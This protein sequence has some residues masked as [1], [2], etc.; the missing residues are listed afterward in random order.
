MTGTCLYSWSVTEM[1]KRWFTNTCNMYVEIK[2]I[3]KND[4]N[5]CSILGRADGPIIDD[6]E[7]LKDRSRKM[8]SRD[9]YSSSPISLSCFVTCFLDSFHPLIKRSTC[10]K[11]SPGYFPRVTL[12]RGLTVKLHSSVVSL[13]G[14]YERAQRKLIPLIPYAKWRC[15]KIVE[16]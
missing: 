7:F 4:T 6:R 14:R 1:I 2:M 9:H 11:R 12:N 16:K 8:F 3:V 5:I 10:L 15:V 13:I